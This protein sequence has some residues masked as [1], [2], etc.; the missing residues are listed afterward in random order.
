[1]K[2]CEFLSYR[3][4]DLEIRPAF[5]QQ[6]SAYESRLFRT[7][8]WTSTWT[9]VSDPAGEELILRNTYINAMLLPM[10]DT[11]SAGKKH[12]DAGIN[13]ADA[14]PKQLVATVIVEDKHDME[15]AGH[16]TVPRR[17][18]KPI[19]KV[20]SSDSGAYEIPSTMPGSGHP[21]FVEQ[22][23]LEDQFRPL[24][25]W[26]ASPPANRGVL[27]RED[28]RKQRIKKGSAAAT[29]VFGQFRVVNVVLLV[30]S[31]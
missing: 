6:L 17:M 15:A 9:E 23:D 16:R 21:V 25:A 28:E 26:T 5:I 12:K 14:N 8:S 13:W 1:M 27:E 3:R 24:D 18:L 10:M 19:I 20:P 31:G 7:G 11:R 4:P 2:T 22:V 30:T 29:E